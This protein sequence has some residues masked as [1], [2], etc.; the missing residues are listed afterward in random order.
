[1]CRM[2]CPIV[3]VFLLLAGCSGADNPMTGVASGPARAAM[4]VTGLGNKMQNQVK[5]NNTETR[6]PLC[7]RFSEYTVGKPDLNKSIS[8]CRLYFFADTILSHDGEKYF[9]LV[10]RKGAA[11]RLNGI[12]GIDNPEN[13]L[14]P[15]LYRW[16]VLDAKGKESRGWLA[17]FL[18]NRDG[19]YHTIVN[20]PPD[21][22]RRSVLE[23][24]FEDV[25]GDGVRED[26]TFRVLVGDIL[27]GKGEEN[28]TG[29]IK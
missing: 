12:G 11:I 27:Y 18:R 25:D 1:M 21:E 19:T 2:T 17:F 14:H 13:Q 23:V 28:G 10:V 9:R 5:S 7:K 29:P 16:K 22:W 20:L 15:Y 26:V 4:P 8:P 24:Y 3:S 6:P